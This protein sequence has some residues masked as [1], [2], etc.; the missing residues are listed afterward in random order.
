[1]VDFYDSYN[2]YK[3][4][5][6]PDL[7]AK[8]IQQFDKEFWQ[9]TNCTSE[10]S[11]LEIGCGTGLFLSYLK[12]KNVKNFIGI[13]SD[14]ELKNFIPAD[15][16]AHFKNVNILDEGERAIVNQKFDII[17]M[18][19]VLEHFE[20]NDAVKLL[21]IMS[22]MLNKNGLIVARLPNAASPWGLSYQYG[23]L[24]HRAAYSPLSLRQLA[25]ASG[26]ECTR[27]YE[28]ITGSPKRRLLDNL[29]HKFL[30]SILMNPPEI[31]SANFFG[32][33]KRRDND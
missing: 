8:I 19:D 31:W 29:L 13:D 22:T 33:L 10:F 21:L 32:I 23:D 11:I 25:L 16:L 9:P 18:F 14:A 7:Q 20:P 15:V 6:T 30:S 27:C 5:S 28:Q 1:M 17:V 26:F 4:Y 24:T 3:S 2:Q 12:H